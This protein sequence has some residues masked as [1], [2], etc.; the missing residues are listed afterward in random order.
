MTAFQPDAFPHWHSIFRIKYAAMSALAPLTGTRATGSV[1]ARASSATPATIPV[2]TYGVPVVITAS[3]SRLD[4]RRMIKTTAEVTVRQAGTEV[5]IMSMLGG[6]YQGLPEGTEIHWYPEAL[7]GIHPHAVVTTGGTTGGV[8]SEGL[9][10]V[11]QVLSFESLGAQKVAEAIWKAGTNDFPAVIVAWEGASD[12]RVVGVGQTL[13]QHSLTAFVVVT[14]FDGHNARR[15]QGEAVLSAV[16]H[17]LSYRAQVDDEIFSSPPTVPGPINRY[18][19]DP[20][21][22]VYA[23]KFS[24]NHATKRQDHRDGTYTRWLRS[25][26]KIQTPDDGTIQPPADP[27]VVV[28]QTE[29]MP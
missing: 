15:E 25:R 27:L 22:Y 13:K 28:D 17:E 14:R 18:A 24:A 26:Q 1:T 8:S 9:V 23:F 7:P 4:F 29:D 10:A 11:K 21:S 3:S 20:G 6:D 16:E 2:N 12:G 5:P 19:M